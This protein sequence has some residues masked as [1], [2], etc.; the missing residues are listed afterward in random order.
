VATTASTSP[1]TSAARGDTVWVGSGRRE[2]RA[3]QQLD[4]IESGW[5]SRATKV[6]GLGDRAGARHEIN[7]GL[8]QRRF[9]A[10][11]V[12]EA[13]ELAGLRSEVEPEDVG[14]RVHA[15]TAHDDIEGIR[16]PLRDDPLR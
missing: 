6:N 14:S 7:S 3:G 5:P 2:V 10:V 11:G 8:P 4:A 16:H 9:Q 13:I 1:N 15:L 12:F